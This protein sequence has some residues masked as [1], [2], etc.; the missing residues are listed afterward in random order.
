MS[1]SSLSVAEFCFQENIS[2]SMFYKILKLG[3]GPRIMKIGRRTLITAESARE[4]RL[5]MEKQGGLK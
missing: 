5:R 3:L 1:K 4:W 2:R